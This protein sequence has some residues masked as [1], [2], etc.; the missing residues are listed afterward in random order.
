MAGGDV[1]PSPTCEPAPAQR[2]AAGR[3]EC[4]PPRDAESG[5]EVSEKARRVPDRAV[6]LAR[7]VEELKIGEV[8]RHIFLCADQTDPKCS[9]KDDSLDSWSFLK[10]RLSELGLVDD[11][12]VYRTKANCLRVCQQG[13]IAVVY[14]DGVWY[15]GCTPEVLERI[16][17][18]HLVG[19][20]PVA[21]HAF[22]THP[23]PA[24]A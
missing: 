10:R 19:G 21:D 3:V 24:P 6:F 12:T 9:R 22:Y 20:R 8:R 4:A 17:Q 14:P 18:E 7:K 11:G 13:P 5:P 15:R 23:L 2:T 1:E 16:I